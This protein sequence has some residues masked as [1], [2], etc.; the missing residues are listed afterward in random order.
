MA[1]THYENFT[2][3]SLLLPRRLVPH[4]QANAQYADLINAL[5]VVAECDD[6]AE[7]LAAHRQAAEVAEQ[8]LG[9]TEQAFTLMGRAVRAGLAEDDL[10]AMVSDY[11]RLA[12]R[13]EQWRPYVDTLRDIAPDVMDA[14]LQ[15]NVMMTI[16]GTSRDKLSD[17]DTA[18]N[19][20]RK[21][22][23]QRPDYGAALDALQALQGAIEQV[24]GAG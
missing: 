5:E 12:E 4:F 13:S 3:V 7:R 19:Y 15:V 24:L 11:G 17:I 6:P 21:V 8:G 20:Y 23:E 22:L 14:D 10:G 18:R 9:D 2:V 1:R 16:A